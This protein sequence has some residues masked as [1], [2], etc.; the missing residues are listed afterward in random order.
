NRRKLLTQ[1]VGGPGEE[2]ICG[3][4]GWLHTLFSNSERV[5]NDRDAQYAAIAC[6]HEIISEESA[7]TDTPAVVMMASTGVPRLIGAAVENFGATDAQII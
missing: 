6:V 3:L 2:V 4:A 5:A 1:G 7:D